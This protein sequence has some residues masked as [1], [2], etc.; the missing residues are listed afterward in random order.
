MLIR[1]VEKAVNLRETIQKFCETIKISEESQIRLSQ[2]WFTYLSLRL[3]QYADYITMDQISYSNAL[4]PI[5][6]SKEGWS[7]K[8]LPFAKEELNRFKIFCEQMNW[9]ATQ[10][11]PDLLFECCELAVLMTTVVA[12]NIIQVKKL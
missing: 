8:K 1:A 9:V 2:I 6:I 5:H 12:K 10:I 7:Q 3:I 11:R 4:E